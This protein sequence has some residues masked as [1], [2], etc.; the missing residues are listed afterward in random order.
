MSPEEGMGNPDITSEVECHREEV[1]VLDAVFRDDADLPLEGPRGGWACT[2][3]LYVLE[4]NYALNEEVETE[5]A[6]ASYTIGDD[7]VCE[8]VDIEVATAYR[9]R[10]LARR[11]MQEVMADIRLKG[12]TRVYVSAYEPEEGSRTAFFAL[13]GFRTME[14]PD[15]T[16]SASSMPF[17]MR[18][19]LE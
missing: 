12:G 13:F 7:D 9:G 18:L 2:I 4:D 6:F 11:L 3:S 14:V 19:D 1:L 5:I 17:P 8:L 16:W 10:G 15:E